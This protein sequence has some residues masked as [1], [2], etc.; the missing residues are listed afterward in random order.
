MY[1]FGAFFVSG[2]FVHALVIAI[3]RY[4]AI[5]YPT[6]YRKIF[7][8]KCVILI[9]LG[10]FLYGL[11]IGTG[12]LFFKSRYVY[13]NK[14]D[15][16][17]A[18]YYDKNVTYYTFS[19][20]IIIYNLTIIF[21]L[22][23]NVANWILIYK[24]RNERKKNKSMNIIYALYSCFTFITTV[25]HEFYF[26]L[27]IIGTYLENENLKVMS[28][29][30]ISYTGEIGTYGDFYFVLIISKKLRNAII[31]SIRNFFGYP[32]IENTNKTLPHTTKC[33]RF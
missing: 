12:T 18:I 28:N 1:S 7:T 32:I 29:I 3:V 4:I 9:I 15:V 19:Y 26:V 30:I 16:I 23:F 11:I 20:S 14:S 17:A 21:S 27:R 25:F 2:F 6:K 31:A 10:M 33:I 5:K 13:N 22:L 8:K 24:K